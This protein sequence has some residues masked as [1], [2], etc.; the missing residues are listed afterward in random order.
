MCIIYLLVLY[1]KL[2]FPNFTIQLMSFHAHYFYCS[3][4]AT[5]RSSRLEGLQKVRAI[6]K[7]LNILAKKL[8]FQLGRSLQTSNV[9]KNELVHWCFS[10][11]LIGNL[12]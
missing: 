6:K 2:T 4:A 7:D 3:C 1:L 11:I 5:F 12:S 9:D 10:M 8:I